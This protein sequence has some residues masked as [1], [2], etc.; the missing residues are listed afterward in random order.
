MSA[1]RTPPA[2]C[3]LCSKCLLPHE[4]GHTMCRE[5]A[6]KDMAQR[7]GAGVLGLPADWYE[8]ASES[9]GAR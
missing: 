2:V 5:C 7:L 3:P 1:P 6:E 9:G 4:L 8:D